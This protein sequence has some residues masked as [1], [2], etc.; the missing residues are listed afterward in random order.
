[1]PE[2]KCF[3]GKIEH[4]EFVNAANSKATLFE[5]FTKAYQK[6][7]DAS[8]EEIWKKLFVDQPLSDTDMLDMVPFIEIEGGYQ[9]PFI[10]KDSKQQYFLDHMILGEPLDLDLL[11]PSKYSMRPITKELYKPIQKKEIRFKQKLMHFKPNT[12]KRRYHK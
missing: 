7:I 6:S 11:L 1:M 9:R 4:P 8:L 2:I 5:S 12:N 3:V 10:P